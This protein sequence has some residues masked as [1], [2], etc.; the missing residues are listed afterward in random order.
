MFYCMSPWGAFDKATGGT[1]LFG[2]ILKSPVRI[3]RCVKLELYW[4]GP[5]GAGIFPENSVGMEELLRGLI[6]D[7]PLVVENGFD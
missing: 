6:G 5:Y 3:L 2:L 7:A 4:Q 1:L